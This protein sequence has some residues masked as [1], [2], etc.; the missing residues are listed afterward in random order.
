MQIV[1]SP[2][3]NP[4]PIRDFRFATA[5]FR[6]F[7][8]NS[9]RAWQRHGIIIVASR[10]WFLEFLRGIIGFGELEAFSSVVTITI[11][12]CRTLSSRQ[13]EILSLAATVLRL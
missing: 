5:C 2:A 3:D 7:V 12:S 8:L 9:L 6:W 1:A 4:A 13:V 10:S 11:S